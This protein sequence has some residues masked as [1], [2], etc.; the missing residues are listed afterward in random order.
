MKMKIFSSYNEDNLMMQHSREEQPNPKMFRMHTHEF[1]ELFLFISGSGVFMIEGTEY[2]LNS[3]DILLMRPAESHYI[4]IDENRAYERLVINFDL[5][6]F[7]GIDSAGTLVRPFTDRP[8]GKLNCY[9][10]NEI[11]ENVYMQ[12]YKTVTM[13]TENKR[14]AILSGLIPLLF[15]IG[16]L[17]EKRLQK[18]TSPQNETLAFQL[19]K[20][21]NMNLNSEISIDELCKNFYISKAQLCRIFKKATGTTIWKYISVKRLIY[22][23][24]Q[25]QS[26]QK[27]TCVYNKCGFNDYSS[28]YRSYV[29]KFGHSPKYDLP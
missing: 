19:V 16:I 23:R 8:S 18:N 28:F 1:A 9:Q 13:K 15:E 4:K 11:N 20:Y 17:F 29:K 25:I 24:S 14:L 22:A 21:V 6:V 26:G 10:S 7:D 27:P 2:P 12:F 3:G 5:S